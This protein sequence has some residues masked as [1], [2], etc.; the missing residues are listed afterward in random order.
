MTTDD[1]YLYLVV[2]G[3][4][5]Q[6]TRFHTSTYKLVCLCLRLRL[7]LRCSY[8]CDVAYMIRPGPKGTYTSP[9]QVLKVE[10]SSLKVVQNIELAQNKVAREKNDCNL[11]RY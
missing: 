3:A 8:E 11:L 10:K 6:I 2:K 7:R 1:T 5:Q 4:M 9:G